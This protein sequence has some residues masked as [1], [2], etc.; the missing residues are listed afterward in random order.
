MK[1]FLS[2]ASEDLAVAEAIN[3]ALRSDGHDVFFD[4]ED[5]P[6]GES[7]HARIRL[8]IEGSD[9]F[10]FLVSAQALDAGSYT[11]NEL[12][13]AQ[14]VWKVPSGRI[15]PVLL[16]PTD[17]RDIPSYLKAVTLLEFRGNVP[18]AVTEAVHRISARRRRKRLKQSAIAV[19]AAGLAAVAGYFL[20]NGGAPRDERA[21]ADGAP[22]LI[23]PAGVF[24]MG[25]DEDS[26]RREVYVD[27]FYIDQFE[28][29]VQ[30]YAKFLDAT[31]L[32]GVPD[33]WEGV[34]PATHADYPAIGVSWRDADEYCRWARKR[35]PTESE[36]EKAARGIGAAT[37]PWGEASPTPALANYENTSPD[38]YDGGLAAVGTYP[39]GRSPFGVDDTA[40]NVS[41][42]VAD[43]WSES[44]P[45]DDR[46]NPRGPADGDAKVIRGGGRYDSGDRIRAT[47]RFY[48]SPETRGDDI[49]FRCAS[50]P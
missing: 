30:R 9:L 32:V 24:T 21:G 33:E 3:L 2:Y 46:R 42:W 1:V 7:F 41:E 5:L 17:L 8:G 25:D 44:F 4:R 16:R 40:G 31:G 47:R 13:I 12:E 11:L 29:T 26:P 14:Q 6:P 38:A 23:V 45:V 18:A 39:G 37:Y 50:D 27:T 10:V 43:W 49:G 28:V 22:E 19:A 36:W 35:L 15:L 20:F 34:D 48:A